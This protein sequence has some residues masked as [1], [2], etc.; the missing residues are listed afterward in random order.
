MSVVLI[1]YRGSGKT[2]VGRKLADRLWLKFVDSDDLIT[3]A[4][5]KSIADILANQPPIPDDRNSALVVMTLTATPLPAFPEAEA[6]A[7]LPPNI[8]LP[9][10]LRSP[11]AALVEAVVDV[12]EKPTKPDDLKV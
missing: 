8:R 5:G 9:A 7:A 2:T 1:G 12:N 6:L 3:A 10:A 11:R 4:A